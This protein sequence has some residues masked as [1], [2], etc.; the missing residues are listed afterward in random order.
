MI[1]MDETFYLNSPLR[2]EGKSVQA[3]DYL[4]IYDTIQHDTRLT[5]N[6]PFFSY[7]QLVSISVLYCTE[8][9]RNAIADT[10]AI[11]D[12]IT[13]TITNQGS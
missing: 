6:R 3:R 8:R 12:T 9:I 13:N 4:P 5:T 11:T 7:S 1:H 10:I 2:I